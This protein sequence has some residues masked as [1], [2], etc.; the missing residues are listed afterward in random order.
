MYPR[1][2]HLVEQVRHHLV[3]MDGS[4]AECRAN[5]KIALDSA[6]QC[7][8]MQVSAAYFVFIALLFPTQDKQLTW[9]QS[10]H[11]NPAIGPR[12]ST[13]SRSKHHRSMPSSHAYGRRRGASLH[14]ALLVPYSPCAFLRICCPPCVLSPLAHRDLAVMALWA[15]F[16]FVL[17]PAASLSKLW[18]LPDTIRSLFVW[19]A[20]SPPLFAQ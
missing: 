11:H 13:R 6:M 10:F 14:E 8:H 19:P 16:L 18:N 7:R 20:T 12:M 1:G 3:S 17:F 9:L 5:P 2:T 15:P 4:S